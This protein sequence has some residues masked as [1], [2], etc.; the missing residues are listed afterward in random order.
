MK[1]TVDE[2]ISGFPENVEEILLK[3]RKT[4]KEAVPKAEEKMKYGI[5]TFYYNENLVHFSG[6]KNHI[7]FYPT[8]SAI[9]KFQK[10]LKGYKTS[11]GAIQFPL[12]KQIPY[13]LISRIVKFRVK[14]SKKKTN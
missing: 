12:D 10:E 9:V 5:P 2:Y 13:S 11:K 3:I 7:G 8:P 1:Q 14:E 4:I 6:C